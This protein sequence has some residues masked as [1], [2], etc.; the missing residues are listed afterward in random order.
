MDAS[1]PLED[2]RPLIEQVQARTATPY[3]WMDILVWEQN[4][5]K[6]KG[7]SQ[8]EIDEALAEARRLNTEDNLADAIAY[9]ER[10]KRIL[11]I[12]AA[13]KLTPGVDWQGTLA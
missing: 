12:Q 10:R 7:H 3:R 5:L 2:S 9:R 8:E 13:E 1:K 11:A 6:L 4:W